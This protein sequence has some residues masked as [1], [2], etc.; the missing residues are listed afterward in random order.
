MKQDRNIHI[1]PTD[2]PSRFSL[3]SSGKYHLTNQLYTNSPNFTNQNIYITSDEI[4]TEYSRG[5]Y[6]IDIYTGRN[7]IF[8][9]LYINKDTIAAGKFHAYMNNGNMCKKIIMTTD[10]ILI[11]N[12]VQPIDDKFLEWFVK[13]PSCEFVEVDYKYDTNLQPI[14]D[15]FGNKVLRIKIPTESSNLS[16]IIIP[17]EEPMSYEEFRKNAS[18]DL[19]RKFDTDC[20]KYSEDGHSDNYFYANCK[21]WENKL[22][23]EP[24]NP[25]NQE[26]MFHEEHQEYF[27]EDIINDKK[28]TVW[29][30]KDYVPKEEPKQGTMSE[31]IKQVIN[32]QLKQETLEEAADKLSDELHAVFEMNN[33]DAFL[34][35]LNILNKG[36]TWQA[37]TM[38]NEEEIHKIVESYQNTMENNP[39]YITYNQ[40]FEQF[41]KK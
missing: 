38:F 22:K 35:I 11:L 31:A 25:N 2:K 3:N 18:N 40:W 30:G 39:T 5:L 33:E 34:W 4:F 32:N 9:P 37:K 14:L 6:F 16:Q 10:P 20:S 21:Y 8:S 26:V 17:Q 12:G 28:V 36:A 41:K 29:L 24:I 7:D 23:E 1:L 15:S 27:Y 19:I 13:N